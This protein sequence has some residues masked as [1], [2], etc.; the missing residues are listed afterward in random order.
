MLAA[1]DLALA[2][3]LL[4]FRSKQTDAAKAMTLPA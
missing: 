2:D 4:S 3:K 1:D